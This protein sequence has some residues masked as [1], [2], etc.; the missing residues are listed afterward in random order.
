MDEGRQTGDDHKTFAHRD[1]VSTVDSSSATSQTGSSQTGSTNTS[2]GTTE[3]VKQATP[4]NLHKVASM[5]FQ[6]F[7]DTIRSKARVFYVSPKK[8][9]TQ[10]IDDI[11]NTPKVH[12]P[13]PSISSMWSYSTRSRRAR[14]SLEYP[15]ELGRSSPTPT[16]AVASPQEITPTINVKIPSS[17]LEDSEH[18]EDD[19]DIGGVKVSS[20]T[21][22]RKPYESRQ[23]WPS[24]I[25]VALQQLS[26]IDLSATGIPR[27]PMIDDP[28]ANSSE[29]FMYDSAMFDPAPRAPPTSP[30]VRGQSIESSGNIGDF[31]SEGNVTGIKSTAFAANSPSCFM[32]T[33]AAEYKDFLFSNGGQSRVPFQ[34]ANDISSSIAQV[35]STVSDAVAASETLKMAHEQAA[36]FS[37]FEQPYELREGVENSPLYQTISHKIGLGD[38]IGSSNNFALAEAGD[39]GSPRPSSSV[40]GTD[41]GSARPTP[42]LFPAMGSR[43]EWEESRADRHNRYY[44]IRSMDDDELKTEEDSEFGVVLERSPGRKSPQNV[45]GAIAEPTTNMRDRSTDL[46]SPDDETANLEGEMVESPPKAVLCVVET[47]A[48]NPA[49]LNISQPRECLSASAESKVIKGL[50]TLENS[51]CESPTAGYPA[52]VEAA[53]HMP[54]EGSPDWSS[55]SSFDSEA[56]LEFQHDIPSDVAWS[57][58]SLASLIN[59]QK[60]K[61]PITTETDPRSISSQPGG[62]RYPATKD[63]EQMDQFGSPSTDTDEVRSRLPKFD[64]SRSPKFLKAYAIQGS[65]ESNTRV[66][67]EDECAPLD[68]SPSFTNPRPFPDLNRHRDH[69]DT[70]LS[71]LTEHS[72]T[73]QVDRLALLDRQ[74]ANLV[75]ESPVSP[76]SPVSPEDAFLGFWADLRQNLKEY[77]PDQEAEETKARIQ[78][79]QNLK[80][81]WHCFEDVMTDLEEIKRSKYDSDDPDRAFNAARLPAFNSISS[82]GPQSLRQTQKNPSEEGILGSA[83]GVGRVEASAAQEIA[84]QRSAQIKS[85]ERKIDSN[86]K[87]PSEDEQSSPGKKSVGW[88]SQVEYIDKSISV[89]SEKGNENTQAPPRQIKSPVIDTDGKV[90]RKFAQRLHELSEMENCLDMIEA[91]PT[92][93]T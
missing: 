34:S 24:P 62:A 32:P 16:R 69:S 76:M 58:V 25:S 4:R 39:N 83:Y 89:L 26:K 64:E 86:R 60:G 15:L 65:A 93:V 79:G 6:S 55:I 14:G 75:P 10:A 85:P 19:N 29:D 56:E 92:M 49:D 45:M 9:G 43:R 5:T 57:P 66:I 38:L 28:E 22:T 90:S 84:H 47:K 40:Y 17:F 35:P 8:T 51:T 12:Q 68:D 91:H 63:Y 74:E 88:A 52:A 21:K 53:L 59:G 20:L 48:K 27:S 18:S 50:D 78:G 44:A 82:R 33:S 46:T 80:E 72:L 3:S 11:E 7:S 37:I 30:E 87:L 1:S 23:L 41:E 81:T 77:I 42:E 36:R 13:R 70:I 54:I 67:S 61:N 31:Q 71:T 2:L 73:R